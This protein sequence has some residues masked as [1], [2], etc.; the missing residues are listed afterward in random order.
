MLE[1]RNELGGR[2]K[3]QEF[4]GYIVEDGANFIHGSYLL[5]DT[6]TRNPLY[7][8]KK[9]FNM[10][11][12]I[13]NY[14]DMKLIINGKSIDKTLTEKY[15]KVMDESMKN[16]TQIGSNLWDEAEALYDKLWPSET[17]D[18]S[19]KKCLY[20]QNYY[21]ADFKI[22]TKILKALTWEIA[23]FE[24][25]IPVASLM[26]NL[27]YNTNEDGEEYITED[28]LVT[29]RR[30]FNIFLKEIAKDF[31]D[32]IKLEEQVVSVNYSDSM[33]K[34]ETEKGMSITG[35]YVICTLPLG[36]LQHGQ[37]S[38]SPPFSSLKE[39]GIHAMT[40]ANY[41]KVSLAFPNNFWG[42]EEILMG[43]RKQNG[44]MLALNL[45]HPKYFPGFVPNNEP[46]YLH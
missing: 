3:N 2:I 29:D 10:T 35:K 46:F 40:M 38:F 44:V 45:D 30:G 41:A 36:V 8:W 34:V 21:L 25:A 15:A 18:I 13:V 28:L 43:I 32:N 14:T 39:K 9:R 17:I 31:K 27:P 42:G 11:G 37:I 12:S 7:A 26:W 6:S 19:V 33:V 1:A 22:D 16:C 4:N 5:S 20:E 23:D 24:T